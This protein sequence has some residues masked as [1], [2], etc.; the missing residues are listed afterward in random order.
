MPRPR[1][2]TRAAGPDDDD[3]VAPRRTSRARKVR[4]VS[5]SDDDSDVYEDASSP[6]PA[7]RAAARGS[8]ARSARGA[9]AVSRGVSTPEA[10]PDDD[11]D[12]EHEIDGQH[13]KVEDDALVLDADAAGDAKV[14][15]QGRLLGGR[16][17]RVPT[18]TS[19]ERS[20]AERLYMLSIDVARVLGY[21][22]SAY[23]FR[24]N[25]KFFKVFLTQDEKDRLVAE[26]R[27][28]SSLRTRNVTMITARA[29]FQQMGARVVARGRHVTDDYYEAQARADG[30]REGAPV[31]MPSMEDILRAE[32]RRESD[33]ERERGRRRPDT[34]SHTTLNAKGDPV[35]TTFGDGGHAPYDRPG[36]TTHRRAMLQR[37]DLAPDNWLAQ[38]AR[39]A[40]DMNAELAAARREHLQALA[41]VPPAPRAPPA[42]VEDDHLFCDTRPPWERDDD[43]ARAERQRSVVAAVRRARR[44]REPVVGVYDP[45]THTPLVSV[46]TQPRAARW[47]KISD[48][49]EGLPPGARHAGLA[50][51][52]VHVVWPRWRSA[53]RPGDSAPVP[54][55]AP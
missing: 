17:Y 22:D 41:P 8:G 29:V 54:E 40:R 38:Y 20:D 30:K 34:F 3:A 21:R 24:K 51:V 50:S 4:A 52:D 47:D 46:A 5:S 1:R 31:A 43:P 35:T 55:A 2:R 28:N 44:A 33:R 49:P 45:H 18:L 25:P 11:S 15:R 19:A 42:T 37:L 6:P 32:W 26:G 27:L 16:S 23:F 36:A 39:S 7:P 48:V 13:Y 12:D 14:D 9:R 53:A 10:T